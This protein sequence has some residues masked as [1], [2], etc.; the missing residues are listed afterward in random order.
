ME[1]SHIPTD[2]EVRRRA[3]VAAVNKQKDRTRVRTLI[4]VTAFGLAVW[5]ALGF[6]V[7]YVIGEIMDTS[8]ISE[9]N[10]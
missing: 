10:K 9:T 3:A 7:G 5:G 4:A 1:N 8:I 2:Y 6:G